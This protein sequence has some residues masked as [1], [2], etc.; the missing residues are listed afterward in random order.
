MSDGYT[1]P[2]GL[3][4][5]RQ[6]KGAPVVY[7]HGL[8][9]TSAV[10][11]PQI[12]ALRDSYSCI[13]FDLRGSG[14]SAADLPLSIEHW[15]DD[16]AEIMDESGVEHASVIGHSLGSL[17]AQHFACSQPHR[18][19]K[20]ALLGVNRS[21]PD[22]R[23]A[24]IL[25][26]A[27][28]VRRNGMASIIDGLLQT[29]LAETTRRDKPT[30]VAAVREMI[31]SQ[32]RFAYARSCEAM[33]ASTRPNL[34]SFDAPVL[35]VAGLDDPVSPPSISKQFA[36]EIGAKLELLPDCG[37]WMPLEQPQRLNRILADFLRD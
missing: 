3:M 18:V 26:R 12:L 11:E 20:L 24:A 37:H 32:D 30:V 14:S 8:G 35:L 4:V 15:V 23:R 36:D 31:E 6:G 9:G 10:W 27:Q 34:N 2:S 16:L 19:D 21:P 7:V 13:H 28:E 22:E 5:Q 1:T 25:Q 17:I 33:A 29:A